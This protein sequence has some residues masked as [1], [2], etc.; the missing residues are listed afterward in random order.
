MQ[1]FLYSGHLFERLA[2]DMCE[3]SCDFKTGVKGS[4]PNQTMIGTNVFC[5]LAQKGPCGMTMIND[6]DD[7]SAENHGNFHTRTSDR[8]SV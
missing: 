2:M 1:T 4:K 6:I 5:R 3:G 7:D 8:K